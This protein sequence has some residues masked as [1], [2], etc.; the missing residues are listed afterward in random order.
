MTTTDSITY[1]V[2]GFA[3]QRWSEI[4]AVPRLKIG[5]IIVGTVVV[6][7]ILAPLIAPFDPEQAHPGEQLLSPGL[8]YWL[9]TDTTGMDIFS[10][11]I[12]APRI[13]LTIAVSA[14]LAAILIGTPWGLF[15][16]YYRNPLSEALM[17]VADLLQSFPVFILGMSLV[18]LTGQRLENVVLALAIVNAPVYARLVRSEVISLKERLFVD[19][20]RAVGSSDRR[21]LVNH[22]LPNASGPILAMSSV[23]VGTAMLVT[24]GLS[25]V[26]AGVRVPTPEWGS[27]IAIGAPELISGGSWWASVFPG[28]AL[29]VTVLGFGMIGDALAELLDPRRRTVAAN[30]PAVGIEAVETI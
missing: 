11:L 25:F 26:G 14:T 17:R 10:R 12:Y 6:I 28:I 20:A 16:G 5:L 1:R 9:G 4:S 24:S 30:A 8:R 18:V 29:S 13:D 2:R 19:S 22:L 27:M 15:A 21:I 7:A 3:R 23:T